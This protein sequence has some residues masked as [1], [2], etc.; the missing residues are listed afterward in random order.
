MNMKKITIQ[1]E[2][3]T[4]ILAVLDKFPEVDTVEVEYDNN[5]GIGYILKISF[6]YVVN[7][8]ATTQTVEITGVDQW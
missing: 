1:K 7:G 2:E 3:L 6:P 5:S 8:V 4:E